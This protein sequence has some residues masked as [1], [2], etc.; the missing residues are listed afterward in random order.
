MYT[1]P[2]FVRQPFIWFSILMATAIA[3][4]IISKPPYL[5]DSPPQ[6]KFP[7]LI[8]TLILL[9]WSFWLISTIRKKAFKT[10]S[11]DAPQFKAYQSGL[12]GFTTIISLF[13]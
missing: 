7:F 3:I 12:I 8:R 5:S 1:L 6:L 11:Y 9:I 13:F 2:K 4:E 10:S